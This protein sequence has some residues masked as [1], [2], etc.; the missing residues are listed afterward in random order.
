MDGVLWAYRTT[1]KTAIQE[2]P[3]AL[4]YGT[5][6]V[7]PAELEVETQRIKQYQLDANEVA[8]IYDL[9]TLENKRN[10]AYATIQRY[11]TSIS[12]A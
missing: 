8:M 2:T 1:P 9:D 12:R 3:F 4:V 5:E 11:Q 6:A 7:I 10:R